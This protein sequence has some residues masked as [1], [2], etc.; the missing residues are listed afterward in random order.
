MREYE[1]KW[2]VDMDL[3]K[4]FD[5]LNHDLILSSV[6][7]GIKDGSILDLLRMFLKSG[8]MTG[9]GWQAA[10]MAARRAG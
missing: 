7:Q 10:K 9:E 1:R 4:C 3:S 6:S 2:V 8:V 5:T